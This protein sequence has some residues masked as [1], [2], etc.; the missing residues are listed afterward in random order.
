EKACAATGYQSLKTALDWL[1]RH[2]NDARL[3]RHDLCNH[4]FI[5]YL[6][7]NEQLKEQIYTYMNESL[8]LFGSNQAHSDKNLTAFKLCTFFQ[9]PDRYVYHIHKTFEHIVHRYRERFSSRHLTL[10][11]IGE[12][13]FFMLYPDKDSE[14]LLKEIINDIQTML[15]QYAPSIVLPLY[16]KQ[17][18]ITL[19]FGITEISSMERK[20]MHD[21]ISTCID[22]DRQ[23]QY[24]WDLRLY[25]REIHLSNY[26]KEVYRVILPI[27]STPLSATYPTDYLRLE[28]DDILFVTRPGKQSTDGNNEQLAYENKYAKVA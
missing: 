25:S 16:R 21:L 20:V 12:Q 17:F 22:F 1:Y 8:Q 27:T 13:Q 5:I 19:A 28:Q 26:E 14:R 15:N 24:Q 23:K 9:V 2:I 4:E 6:C 10:Q 18:H 11:L 7:P 3:D